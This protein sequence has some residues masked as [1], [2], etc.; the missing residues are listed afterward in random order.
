MKESAQKILTSGDD[1]ENMANQS[2]QTSNDICLAVDEISKGALSQA[3]DVEQATQQISDI[4]TLIKQIVNSINQLNENSIIM[5]DEGNEAAEIIQELN[6]SNQ[7]TADAIERI[8]QNVT[9]TNHSVT[10]ITEAVDLITD[11]ACQTDLLSLNA[12]IEAARAGEAGKV[13]P[14]PKSIQN[15]FTNRRSNVI[16]AEYKC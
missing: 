4:G 14:V 1:L 12:S 15:R 11:I 13:F 7:L 6:N 16:L 10:Q 9:A 5:Y 8:G 3:E 2:S